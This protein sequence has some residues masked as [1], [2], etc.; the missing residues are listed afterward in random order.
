MSAS[1]VAETILSQ[2]KLG[3]SDFLRNQWYVAATAH[4]IKERP[5]AR[6]ICDESIVIFRASSGEVSA[7]EDRC[8]HRKAPLSLGTV[9]GDTIQCGYHGARFNGSGR[10]VDIPSQQDLPIPAIFNAK[11]YVVREIHDLVFLW[12]GDSHRADPEL[13]PDWSRNTA[14]GWTAIHGYHHVRCNYQLINDNLLDLSHTQFVHPTTL[15]GPGVN[16][17]PMELKIDGDVVRTGRTIRN[18]DPTPMH[19]KLGLSGK[20]D[21]YQWSDF[22]AP[23][24]T[25]VILSAEP[26]GET[27]NIGQPLFIVMNS[28]VPET[29]H[30]THYFW[31]VARCRLIDDADLTLKYKR[32]V[33][34]AFDEDKAVIE[35]Q[36]RMVESDSSNTPLAVFR[37]DRGG[38]AARRIIMR[39][40]TQESDV[41]PSSSTRG[42]SLTRRIV[43]PLV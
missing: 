9:V 43:D 11:S 36:Q 15:A 25:L 28:A 4:E 18:T 22:M 5:I 20:V 41:T 24:Y 27:Q 31:S 26:V 38:V 33:S 23:C 32:L 8:P 14:K 17:T 16:E 2:A 34:E 7:L 29:A 42:E 19:L 37:G 21:R 39:K 30:T 35:A 13:I 40:M 12:V 3:S 10:C 1:N 6:T